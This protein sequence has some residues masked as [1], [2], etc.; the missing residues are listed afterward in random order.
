VSWLI[1]SVVSIAVLA[2]TILA[3]YR[4]H[5]RW[6]GF[7]EAPTG[8]PSGTK[9]LWDWLQL[10]IVP[11]VLAVAAFWLS[12]AQSR[13]DQRRED[14][15]AAQQDRI[16]AEARRADALG[17]YLQQMSEL[18]L[19]HRLSSSRGGS[20]ASA[21]AQ[22]LTLT[23]LRQLD[24]RRKG[25]VVQFLADANLIR[26][27]PSG[28]VGMDRADLRGASLAGANLDNTFLAGANLRGADF[29]GAFAERASFRDADLRGA[30][31]IDAQV[32]NVAFDNADLRGADFTRAGTV[33]PE[34][35]G[36]IFNGSCITGAQFTGADLIGASFREAE[37]RDV[38]FS[39]ASFESVQFEGARLTDV[40]QRGASFDAGTRR[41][42]PTGWGPTGLRMTRAETDAL[43][44]DLG[45]G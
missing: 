17:A 36:P 27:F 6:T 28:P 22:T 26:N 2:L 12:D 7:V 29:R 15:R 24:G 30:R 3:A 43:C 11:L 18:V 1:Y 4:R 10:L 39:G 13:R 33:D 9:T 25:V 8:T 37:G 31:F 38:N 44:K 35:G 19:Q 40:I 32:D 20:G 34:L 45:P 14:R 5:W 41:S 21:L 23:V 42:L 16:A